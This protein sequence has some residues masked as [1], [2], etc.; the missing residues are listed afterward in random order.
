MPRDLVHVSGGLGK[1]FNMLLP[2]PSSPEETEF[3]STHPHHSKS[4]HNGFEL[5]RVFDSALSDKIPLANGSLL[6][7]IRA[8]L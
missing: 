8:W 6:N 2:V 1:C 7:R 5:D 3:T 4:E